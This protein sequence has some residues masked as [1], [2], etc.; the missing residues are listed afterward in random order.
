[1]HMANTS[2]KS[3]MDSFIFDNIASVHKATISVKPAKNK[4]QQHFLKFAAQ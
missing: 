4:N 3:V 1:M 2:V